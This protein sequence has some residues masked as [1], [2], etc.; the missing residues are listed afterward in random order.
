MIEAPVSSLSR[1]A[2]IESLGGVGGTSLVLAGMSALGFGI[3]ARAATP[4]S[5]SG[6]RGKKVVIL[7]SGVAG[8]T[9][10]YELSKAGYDVTLLE[11]RDRFGG[12][13][14]TARKGTKLTEL[15]GEP[16]TCTFD[17]GHYINPGPWRIPYHHKGMLHYAK[18]FNVPLELFNNDNDHSYIYFDK[19]SG[20]LAG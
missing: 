18:M 5:L 13:S 12:R 10:A 17:E 1:R 16:Q 14:Y 2:F 7:G 4:P 15:G 6:G 8:L 11:A 9:S 20:P 19:G 3:E